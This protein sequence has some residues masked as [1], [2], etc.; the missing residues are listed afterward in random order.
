METID[1]KLVVLDARWVFRELSGI[2]RYTL[3]LLRQ[4]G[5]LGGGWRFL[6]LVRDAERRGFIEREAG[7]AGKAHVEFAELPH[8]V[9]SVR[10]QFAAARLLRERGVTVYHSTNFMVPLLSAGSLPPY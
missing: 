6:V 10:G 1:G 3:V 7:L 8:G 2:G 9:F 5:D 4:L